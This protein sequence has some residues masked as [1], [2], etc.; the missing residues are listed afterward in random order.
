MDSDIFCAML[1]SGYGDG[2]SR[3]DQEVGVLRGGGTSPYHGVVEVAGTGR[4]D[5]RGVAG[6]VILSAGK[7]GQSQEKQSS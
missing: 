5:G 1:A 2:M 7:W 6:V 3:L 4:G